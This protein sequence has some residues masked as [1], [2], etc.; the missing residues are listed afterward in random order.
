M[1]NISARIEG[2]D[3]VGWIDSY[4]KRSTDRMESIAR[5][6]ICP[7]LEGYAKQN[8]PWTD[9][10]GAARQGLR[11][12]FSRP[13][14]N[15]FITDIRHGVDYGDHLENMQSGRFS[16]LRPTVRTMY[17]QVVDMYLDAWR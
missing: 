8:A 1:L 10:T 12:T 11:S 17:P 4:Y 6:V 15:V 3:I 14:Q 13:R 2:D 7:A 16:I 5:N 9:R